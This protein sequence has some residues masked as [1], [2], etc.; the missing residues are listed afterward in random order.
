MSLS[1]R[2]YQVE[3]LDRIAASSA[4][5]QLAVMATGTGK[6]LL[7]AELIRRRQGR[8]V[9]LVDQDE[10]VGQTVRALLR[11]GLEGVGVVQAARNQLGH[12]H[13]VAT[14][15]SLSQ[16]RRLAHYDRTG[17]R[18]LIV[19]E[20]H[21][22]RAARCERVILT[23]DA[24]LTVGLTATPERSDGKSIGR[25]FDLTFSYPITQALRDG[26][27]VAPRGVRVGTDA[28]LDDALVGDDFDEARLDEALV[29]SNAPAQIA[30]AVCRFAATRH[31]IV[32][33][34]RVATAALV[35][36]ECRKAGLSAEV[37]SARVPRET[38][39]RFYRQH[40]SGDLQVLANVGVL[41]TGY[42]DP[43]VDCIVMAR[44][45]THAGLYRQIVGRG[46]RL[47]PAK[48]DLLVLDVVGATERH[49]LCG[50][51]D[52]A[53]TEEERDRLAVEVPVVEDRDG[54]V[55]GPGSLALQEFTS[56]VDLAGSR[57]HF[58]SDGD[59]MFL[60]MA[61]AG[62]LMLSPA[63]EDLWNVHHRPT[64]WS[65]PLSLIGESL[66]IEEAQGVA[67][68]LARRKGAMSIAHRGASWRKSPPTAKQLANL[69][70][71]GL[72]HLSPTTAQEASDILFRAYVQR[73]RR[74]AKAVG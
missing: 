43:R 55:D 71:K 31:T 44:P 58:I 48:A 68:D 35:V 56:Y 53:E 12:R 49:D 60:P 2:P 19:D 33:V 24:P 6:T 36:E 42:D 70:S 40:R 20:A 37:V 23:L 1:L 16:P 63:G 38:R 32:F 41:T 72:G 14:V 11:H 30:R 47:H 22:S 26:Y 69:K 66:T 73:D 74:I 59:R 5:R 15:Q 10:L 57:L 29:N 27:L 17:L 65:A 46:L 8:S 18:T 4:R 64:S 51:A 52:L 54:E 67:E 61:Q 50:I 13:V 62:S 21:R 25:L 28:V 39:E 9:F 7:A 3:A 45:T 34:P